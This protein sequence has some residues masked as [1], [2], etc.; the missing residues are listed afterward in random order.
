MD[1]GIALDRSSWTPSFKGESNL[2]PCPPA[3]TVF[4]VHGNEDVARFLVDESEACGWLAKSFGSAEG[5][6]ATPPST[7]P[8]CLVLDVMMPGLARHDVQRRVSAESASMPM[9]L[10]SG[11]GDVL[12]VVSTVQVGQVTLPKP[13]AGDGVVLDAIRHAL[14]R[15]RAALR[16]Q[17]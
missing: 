7:G 16:E 2:A 11:R 8:S 12:M 5:F 14:D 6:L 10:V 15:S 1:V 13:P 4:L 9:I 3:G 17:E